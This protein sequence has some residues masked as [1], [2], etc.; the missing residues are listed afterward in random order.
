[1]KKWL[2]E[3]EEKTLEI[4]TVPIALSIVTI[5][6]SVDIFL[7]EKEKVYLFHI[8]FQILIFWKRVY[9]WKKKTTTTQ[10]FFIL[11]LA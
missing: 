1:M 3:D 2:C 6:Y 11:K 8:W 5:I 7:R 4:S 9:T 10:G